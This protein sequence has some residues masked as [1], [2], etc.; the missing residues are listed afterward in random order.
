M[1]NKGAS[2]F[3]VL[4]ANGSDPDKV[5]VNDANDVPAD[6]ASVLFDKSLV[7]NSRNNELVLPW[8][9]PINVIIRVEEGAVA[10]HDRHFEARMHDLEITVFVDHIYP[11]LAVVLGQ[12]FHVVLEKVDELLRHDILHSDFDDVKSSAIVVPHLVLH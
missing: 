5:K 11:H 3:K 8:L 4:V 12:N 9:A 1:L 6:D 10:D 7:S 2:D